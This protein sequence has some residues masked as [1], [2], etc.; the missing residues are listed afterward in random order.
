MRAMPTLALTYFDAPGRAEPIRV[1]LQLANLPFEDHRL[2]FPTFA[3]QKAKGAFPLGA[4][5]VLTVDGFAIPQTAA[6]LRDAARLGN[7]GLYP[8]DPF[9]A[10]LVDSVLDTFNDTLSHALRPSLFERD[11]A[12]KL[13][14]R[15]ELTT[16]A[17]ATV[18]GFV[19]KVLER[20]GG[21]F[22]AG[23]HM[24]IADIVV[25]HQI[26]QIRDGHLDGIGPEHLEAYPRTRKLTDAYL[27]EPRIAAL[28][29]K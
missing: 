22:V 27:A 10:L 29:G 19:E 8:A 15:K 25:A 18:L 21:P 24:S 6:M 28:R 11:M 20:S 4:V 12:K 2:Q 1:A 9:A 14:M 5:P 3:E 17:M 13:E 23:A 26:L 7:T 16:G